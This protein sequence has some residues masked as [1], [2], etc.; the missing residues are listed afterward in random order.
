MR[1]TLVVLVLVAISL[2]VEAQEAVCNSTFHR[3][4]VQQGPNRLDAL[5]FSA[6]DD[7]WAVGFEYDS[8]EGGPEYPFV[9][10][11]DGQ[12]WSEFPAPP[13]Q[14]R[15]DVD[16]DEVSALAPDLVW[17]AAQRWINQRSRVYIRV[18][19]GTSWSNPQPPGLGAAQA[20]RRDGV[21]ITDIE[22]LAADDA[23]AV[24]LIHRNDVNRGVGLHYN[25]TGWQKHEVDRYLE[26]IEARAS[27]Q[28]WGVGGRRVMRFDGTSWRR[29]RLPDY[30]STPRRVS[31][32]AVHVVNDNEVW[33]LGRRERRRGNGWITLR[34]IGRG[35]EIHR[36]PPVEKLEGYT[37]IDGADDDLWVVG[38]ATVGEARSRTLGLRWDGTAWKTVPV[39]EAVANLEGGVEVPAPGDAWALAFDVLLRACDQ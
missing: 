13:R 18:W 6:P 32:R 2:P 23:W 12:S 5:D 35:W 25:G 33:F 30:F 20:R 22:A 15:G 4:Y 31:F 14:R 21:F 24:G 17:V 7:G 3:D 26:D 10:H 1:R 34:R 27:G 9:V 38:E 39:E 37:D 36:L 19:D 16:L 29:V 28:L 11:F 8:E